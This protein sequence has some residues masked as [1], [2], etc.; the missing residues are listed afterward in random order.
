[1]MSYSGVRLRL[2]GS[3]PL[4]RRSIRQINSY[5][6]VSNEGRSQTAIADCSNVSVFVF[7]ELRVEI[8]LGAVVALNSKRASAK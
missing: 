3:S 1:M 2:I 5:I 6:Q 7:R 4:G 8:G